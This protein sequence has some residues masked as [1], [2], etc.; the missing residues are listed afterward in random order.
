MVLEIEVF[1][2]VIFLSPK[3]TKCL[4]FLHCYILRP[5]SNLKTNFFL[6]KSIVLMKISNLLKMLNLTRLFDATKYDTI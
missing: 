3:D 1:D 4:H 2:D 5:I 6:M